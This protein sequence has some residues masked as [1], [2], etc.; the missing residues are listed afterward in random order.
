[1]TVSTTTARQLQKVADNGGVL[2]LLE[3]N[4]ASFSAPVRLVNDTRNIT[5]L[6][7]EW[8]A[9]PFSITLPNDKAKE[10]QRA[11]LQMD[12]VG[13]EITAELEALPPGASIKA[14]IR[15][16]HRSTPGV[17]DF[18]F[19]APLSGVRV[20]ATAVSATMGR[21]DIMRMSAVLLR[22]DPS[23]APALFTE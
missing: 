6:G 5:T 1:M 13:R 23:T 21:D 4:H 8:L 9:L 16:V 3:I 7:Y 2:M 18:Q 20:D 17:I 22:F 12:N 15:M 19:A 14:T 11:R 10:V